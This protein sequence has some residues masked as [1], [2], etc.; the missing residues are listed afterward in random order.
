MYK[1]YSFLNHLFQKWYRSI[2]FCHFIAK[3]Y[4]V[5]NQYEQQ[6]GLYKNVR[7]GLLLNHD[8]YFQN[9]SCTIS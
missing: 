4:A 8:F 7:I 3:M 9:V 6:L 5:A 2:D 1:R